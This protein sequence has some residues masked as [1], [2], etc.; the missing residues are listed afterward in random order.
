MEPRGLLVS[1]VG[2]EKP[3]ADAEPR[4]YLFPFF[5]TKDAGP[6]VL[7]IPPA[8]CDYWKRRRRVAGGLDA[9]GTFEF[10]RGYPTVASARK[11]AE[12]LTLNRAVEV[13]LSLMHGV[14][15]Y[16]VWPRRRNGGTGCSE[17]A[18]HLGS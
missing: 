6:M 7:E 1:S 15:W 18:R 12:L 5:N 10:E 13:F 11:L 17:P 16:A 2:L 3:D 14:S 8:G 9:C 4:H